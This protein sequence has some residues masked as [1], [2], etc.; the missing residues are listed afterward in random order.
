MRAGP[1]AVLMLLAALS[2]ALAQETAPHIRPP[3]RPV[4]AE[5][6]APEP[7]PEPAPEPSGPGREQ[8]AESD[9]DHSACLLALSRLGVTYEALPPITDPDRSECGIDRPVR[10]TEVRPGIVLHGGAD[11]RCPVARSLAFWTRDFVAPAAARLPGAPRLTGYRP[12]ST[13]QC[14]G[15]IGGAGESGRLSEHA[16]GNAIDIAAFTFADAPDL[17]IAP[18]EGS[19][20]AEMAFQHAVRATACLFFTTVLGP[21][22]DGAHEDHLHLDMA[23]RRG[24]WRL[25]Q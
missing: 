5:T 24:D 23:Q 13:Y 6:P 7:E 2:P 22:S 3:A 19:G 10:V 25:C 20:S 4:V 8:F 17:P 14:R 1:G 21:G 9:F 12:G 16:L 15:R 18:R 11:M